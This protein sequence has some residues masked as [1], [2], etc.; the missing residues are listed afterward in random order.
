MMHPRGRQVVSKDRNGGGESTSVW[1]F[2]VHV[3]PQTQTG[4][5]MCVSIFIRWAKEKPIMI[6][7]LEIKEIDLQMT[8]NGWRKGRR[9]ERNTECLQQ[10][11]ACRFHPMWLCLQVTLLCVWTGAVQA[12][13]LAP[14]EHAGQWL[15]VQKNISVSKEN[16]TKRY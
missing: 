4:M 14:E 9:G 15:E 8:G 2:R 3:Y 6:V 12:V 16:E 7:S 1:V 5:H 10:R 11:E 13:L